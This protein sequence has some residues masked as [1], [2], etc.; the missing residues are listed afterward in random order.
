MQYLGQPIT[1][2][3]SL[4]TAT[5]PDFQRRGLFRT[6][7][8]ELYAASSDRCPI[9]FGFPN[10][11]SAPSFYKH[12]GWVDVRPFPHLRRPL[13]G[14]GGTGAAALAGRALEVAG[15]VGRDRSVEVVQIADFSGVADPI[16][17]AVAPTAGVAIIRDERFLNWRFVESPYPYVRLAAMRDGVAVGLAVLAGEAT[18]GRARLMEL[19]VAPT[20]GAG[21]VRALLARVVELAN[22]IG[23]L[24]PRL[25]RHPPPSPVPPAAD[26]RDDPG[27]APAPSP[28]PHRRADELL[29]SPDQRAGSGSQ[30]CPAHRRLVSLQ[31]RP[32]LDLSIRTTWAPDRRGTPRHGRQHRPLL[33]R[34]Q[35]HLG[36]RAIDDP[37]TFERQV[38]SLLDAGYQ[39]VRFSEAVTRPA[40]RRVFAVTFD[41]A[42]RSVRELGQPILDRLQ[43]PATVFAPTDY[44]G[45]E[46]PMAWPGIEHWLGGRFEHELVPMSWEELAGLAAGGWEIGSHTGS[47][48]HLTQLDTVA[49]ADELHRSKVGL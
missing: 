25:R 30:P 29:R 47:H 19:L 21:V 6:L 2:L 28:L 22:D 23:R 31:R 1:G 3:L 49:L 18:G 41:D 20:E 24:R 33:P 15:R 48:P 14:D 27:A 10:E 37:R 4:F 43:V 26:R 40:T 34:A 36:R 42:Y 39:P 16:W 38:R 5:D 32:G 8:Q 7:A 12:L 9:V 13:R 11:Q 17:E 46:R 45:T 35:P 44:I